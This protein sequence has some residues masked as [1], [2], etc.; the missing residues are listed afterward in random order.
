LLN[1]GN[2]NNLA[3]YYWTEFKFSVSQC[4]KGRTPLT[5]FRKKLDL[6]LNF[7]VFMRFKPWHFSIWLPSVLLSNYL[8]F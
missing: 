4:I 8:I 7:F 6:L 2:I 5:N 1:K 3:H